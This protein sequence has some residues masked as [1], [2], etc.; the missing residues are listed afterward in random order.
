LVEGV[1]VRWVAGCRLQ[2]AGGRLQ[3]AG[4]RWKVAGGRLQVEGC[5]WKVGY[6]T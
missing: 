6:F 4:C 3:V 5:R 2:V 1:R